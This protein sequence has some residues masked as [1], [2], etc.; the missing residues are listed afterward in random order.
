MTEKKSYD[1]FMTKMMGLTKC[2]WA[3]NYDLFECASQVDNPLACKIVQDSDDGLLEHTMELY[4][5]F[6][7]RLFSRPACELKISISSL[8]KSPN[9]LPAGI[10][11]LT[12]SPPGPRAL[13]WYIVRA[14]LLSGALYST[15]ASY[16]LIIPP[17]AGSSSGV[18]WPQTKQ[19]A[20]SQRCP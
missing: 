10:A 7:N 11:G 5:K 13:F 19:P 4:T 16:A 17:M 12:W 20:A 9:L 14:A 2:I 8:T 3:G 15:S 18:I 6:K 1:S